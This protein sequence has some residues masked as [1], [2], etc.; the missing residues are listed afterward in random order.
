[1]GVPRALVLWCPDWPLTAVG[2]DPA[3]PAAVVVAGR[4]S[5]CT[6]AARA[7]GVRRGQ[8]LRDAQRYCPNVVVHDDDPDGQARAFEL[9]VGVVEELC[10]RVEVIRPGLAA[11]PAQGPS[12]YYGGEHVV[13]GLIRDAVLDKGFACAVGVADGTFAAD[14]AA[15]AAWDEADREGIYVVASRSTAQFLAPHPVSTLELPGL[16]DVLIRLGVR[17]LGDLAALPAGDVLAR[18][19]PD[20]A[21]AHR[22]AAGLRHRQLVTRPPGDDLGAE[23]EF[24]PPIQ[25]SEPAVFAAKRLADQLHQN[26]A[27]H[28]LTC[29]RVE[30]EAVTDDGHSRSRLWRHDGLLSSLAVAERVRWQLDA[31]RTAGELTGALASLR[32]A[33][34]Q[35][36]VDTGRQQAVWG[37]SEV[38]QQ[39]SRAAARL[40]VMLGH[41]AVTTPMLVGGRGPGE[42]VAQAPWGD[43]VL[44]QGPSGRLA[45]P[46]ASDVLSQSPS[47]RSAPPRASGGR[48][49]AAGTQPWPGQV[50]PPAPS[51]VYP[52]PVSVQVLDAQG[53][54]VTVSGRS[55]VSAPPARLLFSDQALEI[56]GWAGPWPVWEHWWDVARERRRARLQVVTDDGR[57]W[58]LLIE[59]GTWSA[60]ATY[61]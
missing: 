26:L 1:M 13:A 5:S 11:A 12:R 15:R 22:L 43:S 36:T 56:T 23:T 30:V 60:E 28:G 24:D 3:V 4:V 33:P 42:Q 50:P 40:Q 7:A 49:P 58:L 10:P 6:A 37:Q 20:G 38:S 45:P 51:V 14:L 9:V 41:A 54:L 16:T 46:Q 29:T 44:S 17:T 31:W 8:R 61:M 59:R 35:V 34:D 27:A 52:R 47:G 48:P 25:Q 39:V 55:A 57:A 32:L 53:A 18:F 2:A 19:G 21:A